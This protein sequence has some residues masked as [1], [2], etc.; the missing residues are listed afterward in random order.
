MKDAQY[1]WLKTHSSIYQKN[2]WMKKILFYLRKY[3][4]VIHWP[5]LGLLVVI[6]LKIYLSKVR[7]QNPQDIASDTK[8][9][10]PC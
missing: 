5:I 10:Y 2:V 9:T 1:Y 7:S 4:F 6:I 3:S 8:T